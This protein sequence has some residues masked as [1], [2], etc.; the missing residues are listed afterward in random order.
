MISLEGVVGN[1]A[2]ARGVRVLAPAS[3]L[4]RPLLLTSAKPLHNI[5][6]QV[7]KCTVD[8]T[9]NNNNNNNNNK[10]FYSEL[11]IIYYNSSLQTINELKLIN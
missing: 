11:L 6:L 5:I 8:V 9:T 10:A 7:F 4:S 2:R 3:R 1:A